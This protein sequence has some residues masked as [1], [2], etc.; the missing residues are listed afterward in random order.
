MLALRADGGASPGSHRFLFLLGLALVL[1]LIP[2]LI[3]A[4]V[5]R[6]AR[7]R[8][9]L[10]EHAEQGRAQANL[11]GVLRAA[12][13]ISIIATD[14][15]GVI[16]VF[17]A[18][19]EHILGYQAGELVGKG[20]PESF[21]LPAELEAYAREL[22]ERLGRPV[23]GFEVFVVQVRENGPEGYDR[24]EWT[25]VRKDGRHVPVEL[26][27][28]GVYSEAGELEGFLGVGQD[29]SVR[30][31]LEADLRQA[32]LSVDSASDMILW[33]RIEDGRITYA[34]Q[35]ASVVLGYTREELLAMTAFDLNPARTQEN[36]R[37]HCQALRAQGHITAEM[38]FRRRDGSLIPVESAFSLVEHGGVEYSL[39]IVRD[40][41][42]RK[43]AEERLQLET[44]LNRSLAEAARTLLAAAPD[45]NEVAGLLL[46]RARELTGSRH[47]YVA[48]FDQQADGMRPC[49]MSAMMS[50]GE[51]ALN[52][53]SSSFQTEP[54]GGCRGLWG[55]S[56]NMRLGFFENN[57]EAHPSAIGLPEGHIRIEQLL[58]VPALSKGRLVGQIALANPG[59]DYTQTDLDT[60]A[61]LADIFALGAEQVLSQRDL[62]AAKEEAES[63]SR[64]K[65]DFL[66]NMTHEVRTPLNG[67]LGMLQV[68]QSTGLNPDQQ[69]YANVALES[70]ERL[71]QLLSNVIEYAR[72]DA[73]KGEGECLLFPP[74]DLLNALRAVY[75]PQARAKGLDFRLESAPGLP[76]LVRTDPQALRQIL[77]KLLD[78]AIKFTRVG[79]VG[80][81]AARDP[82]NAEALVFRVEDS[83]I[84]IPLE[85]REQIFEAFVQADASITRT[86]G[87]AGLGL[88]IARRQ[89]RCM[90]GTLEVQDRPGGG[91]VMLLTIPAD[92]S[93]QTPA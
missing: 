79:H 14:A 40:I 88:A 10:L 29:L 38:N 26:T 63:S 76:E 3:L 52:K 60:V 87:G 5:L 22:T 2:T 53:L 21:H 78:N 92:C 45:M 74:T 15:L 42:K 32:Q 12:N 85:K 90:G 69:E 6:R 41:A 43:V 57:P 4:L 50:S 72:L 28:T 13:R 46:G 71:N 93:T 39:G 20:T 51:C 19:A 44:R 77:T 83:G 84:G 73:F 31:A 81:G 16:Q 61:S 30:K 7:R 75:E 91:T 58:T 35:A 33:G 66:T 80:L 17:N 82:H 54:G 59:R 1:T 36:W 56:L 37:D 70:A 25:Y 49:V 34:N 65:S 86:F 62:L 27:V 11:A 47:G 64:A 89:A 18:G 8:L 48:F 55:H 9:R 24:R 68:L 67:V 23:R